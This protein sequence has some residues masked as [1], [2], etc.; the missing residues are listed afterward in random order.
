[1]ESHTLNMEGIRHKQDLSN[2]ERR[3]LERMELGGEETNV[4]DTG[5]HP[6]KRPPILVAPGFSASIHTN[7]PMLE[8]FAKEARVLSLDH[9]HTGNVLE[10]LTD[11]DFEKAAGQ[12]LRSQ[13]RKTSNILELLDKKGVN[14]KVNCLAFSEGAINTMIAAYLRPEKFNSIILSAPAGLIGKDNLFSLMTRFRAQGRT[15][16]T[17]GIPSRENFASQFPELA[18]EED[19]MIEH[20]ARTW[21]DDAE[22]AM[23]HKAR[24]LADLW[25]IATTRIDDLILFAR[26][27]GIKVAVISGVDDQVFPIQRLAKDLPPGSLDGFLSVRGAHGPHYSARIVTH[28]FDLLNQKRQKEERELTN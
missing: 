17:I 24:T 16:E 15:D 1:M 9:P 18:A 25:A 12:F 13:M 28:L 5:E 27:A 11:E 22:A 14:E 20:I 21:K 3:Y 8:M 6:D 26:A 4:L 7:A 23:E 2:I 10:G 19:A